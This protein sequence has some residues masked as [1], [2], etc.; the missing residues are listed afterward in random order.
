MEKT[1]R[2]IPKNVPYLIAGFLSENEQKIY[3]DAIKKFNNERAKNSLDISIKGSNLFKVLLL[4]QV[5]IRT[6]TL[7]ELDQIIQLDNNFLNGT[8]EDVPSLVLRSNEDTYERNDYLAE[9]LAKLIKKRK[10]N[11]PV[12]MNGLE[13]V[14]DG[15]SFYGLNFKRGKTFDYFEAP[16]L[17]NKNNQQKFVRQDERGMPIFDKKGNRTLYTRDSGLSGLY[18]GRGLDLYSD[19]GSLAYS[20]DYGRVVVVGGE[21]TSQKIVKRKQ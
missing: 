18:L 4:N 7:P 6:A 21:A 19:G 16:E 5:G 17:N 20:I 12:V 2:F 8:Y 3:E 15:N 1:I 13:L 9:T 10:F 11:E 14:E